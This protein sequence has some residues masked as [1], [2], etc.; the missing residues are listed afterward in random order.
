MAILPRTLNYYYNFPN[1]VSMP[2]KG[3][4]A[5]VCSVIAWKKNRI[6]P[7][8]DRFLHLRSFKQLYSDS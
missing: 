3:D 8:T 4:D 2:I 6:N 5:V 1:V 7:D